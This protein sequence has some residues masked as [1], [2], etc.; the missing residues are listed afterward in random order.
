LFRVN[1]CFSVFVIWTTSISRRTWSTPFSTCTVCTTAPCAP[2]RR[3]CG[4]S[5]SPHG[6]ASV[7]PASWG[8]A[9]SARA[10]IACEETG[11]SASDLRTASVGCCPQAAAGNRGP[12]GAAA[13]CRGG[14]TSEA[15]SSGSARSRYS[16]TPPRGRP[17]RGPCD[18]KSRHLADND[19]NKQRTDPA[20][21]Y[22][23]F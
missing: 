20:S 4:T 2:C 16:R 8:C 23:V 13:P 22:A 19:T 17:P 10:S 21:I 6:P 7:T 9:A 11:G 5:C 3:L 1:H 18:N 14:T 12:R 15:D